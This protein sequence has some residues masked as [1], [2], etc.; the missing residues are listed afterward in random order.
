M[1][2]DWTA[3]EEAEAKAFQ[4]VSLLMLEALSQPKDLAQ[5]LYLILAQRLK[6]DKALAKRLLS[7]LSQG[8]F[9]LTGPFLLAYIT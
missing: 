8:T 7:A 1:W 6:N 5:G 9:S 4:R 2:G 3:Q